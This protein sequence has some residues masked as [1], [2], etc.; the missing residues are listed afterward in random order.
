MSRSAVERVTW[1]I[2]GLGAAATIAAYAMG[3]RHAAASAAAGA[4]VAVANWLLLRFI[5]SRV[6]SGTVKN[7]AAFSFVLVA[8]MGALMGIIFVV[9]RSGLVQSI[10]FTVGVSTLVVGSLVGSLVS[11]LTAPAAE[12]KR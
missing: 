12:G 10:P 1:F 2:L 9:L 11:V 7:Q 4:A 8:K 3:G 6:V 5:V